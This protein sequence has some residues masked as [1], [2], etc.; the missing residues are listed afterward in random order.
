MGMLVVRMV[1]EGI[2]KGRVL[3]SVLKVEVMAVEEG[4]DKVWVW[5][6]YI[7]FFPVCKQYQ[8]LQ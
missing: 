5:V 1:E 3:V 6:W 8:G 7:L 2:K 4:V